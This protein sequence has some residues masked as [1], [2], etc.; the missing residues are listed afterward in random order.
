MSKCDSSCNCNCSTSDSS[1]CGDDTS[2]YVGKTSRDTS[3]PEPPDS[4]ADLDY[5][6]QLSSE[7]NK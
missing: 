3:I 1:D 7:D 2:T 6:V 4:E 5:L